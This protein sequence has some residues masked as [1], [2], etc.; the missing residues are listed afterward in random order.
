[1]KLI[2]ST[3]MRIIMPGG[4]HSQGIDSS[5]VAFTMRELSDQPI[6]TV[7][8]GFNSDTFD[9]L[10]YALAVAERCAARAHH[11]VLD[12]EAIEILDTLAWHFD[13]PFGD[14]S[15]VPTY[16][17]SRLA[18]RQL[19]VCLAG[20]GGDEMF[21]GYPRFEPKGD[22]PADH[23]EFSATFEVYPEVTPGDLSGVSIERP[24]LAVTDAEVEKTIEVLRIVPTRRTNL[25][26]HV[27]VGEGGEV[28]RGLR[29]RH[30]IEIPF[31][32][33]GRLRPRRS[34]SLCRLSLC[35]RRLH[36]WRLPRLPGR[37]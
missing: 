28:H 5:T 19:T 7:S 35:G 26:P 9:E 17:L 27:R 30:G 11:R 23:L 29:R 32:P 10:P 16:H 8:I 12:A 6:D 3:E 34:L 15:M 31:E 33:C 24:T 37:F 25:L 4:T 13:E 20:D 1:M 22:A 14:H 2:A 36:G 18:R 21:A